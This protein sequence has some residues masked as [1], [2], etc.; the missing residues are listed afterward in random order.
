V[1]S[2]RKTGTRS[3][4][5]WN[6][7]DSQSI[8]HTRTGVDRPHEQLHE[9]C[10]NAMG[11]SVVPS[12]QSAVFSDTLNK[13]SNLPEE[14]TQHSNHLY[15]ALPSHCATLIYG[16]SHHAEHHAK[17]VASPDLWAQVCWHVTSRR[18]GTTDPPTRC[19]MPQDLNMQLHHCQ[20]LKSHATRPIHV[21]HFFYTISLH[22][23]T[24]MQPTRLT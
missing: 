17:R 21:P 1:E 14:S 13:P 5:L 16:N 22:H 18:L 3:C 23:N 10:C 11:R 20:N 6:K 4:L 2:S 7:A 8:L 19:H 24:I 15:S 12:G 9:V